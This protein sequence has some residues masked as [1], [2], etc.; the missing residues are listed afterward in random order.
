MTLNN[1]ECHK[2]QLTVELFWGPEP[3]LHSLVK[4]QSNYLLKYDNDRRV[5]GTDEPALRS[6]WKAQGGW[7]SLTKEK[8][9]GKSVRCE[10]WWN[11]KKL[12]DPRLRDGHLVHWLNWSHWND[13]QKAELGLIHCI[14][15]NSAI[16]NYLL[17]EL[18]LLHLP[19]LDSKT[20]NS[21]TVRNKG[22][23]QCIC[24]INGFK[25][26]NI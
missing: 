15:P 10:I 19:S 16:L 9:R 11:V 20:T 14:V 26:Q 13:C 8:A 23:W 3:L 21:Y 6:K 1:D 25:I 7:G 12:H 5:W 17:E 18:A 24:Q 22:R 2:R 4:W